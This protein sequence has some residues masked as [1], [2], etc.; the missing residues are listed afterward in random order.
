MY[1]PLFLKELLNMPPEEET[2]EE[3]IGENR[4]NNVKFRSAEDEKNFHDPKAHHKIPAGKKLLPGN[5]IVRYD[6][7]DDGKL[8]VGGIL[9]HIAKGRVG[10]REPDDRQKATDNVPVSYLFKY[11]ENPADRK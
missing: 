3:E 2:G 4:E 10:I 8:Y 5:E 1:L 7:Q 9:L 11:R 6:F